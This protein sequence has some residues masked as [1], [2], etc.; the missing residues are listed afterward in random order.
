MGNNRLLSLGMLL[1]LSCTAVGRTPQEMEGL[2]RENWPK[3]ITTP[4]LRITV[5]KP[6]LDSLKGNRIRLRSAFSALKGEASE[7]V[8][9]SFWMTGTLDVS[10]DRK[11]GS[12]SD[13][14]VAEVR[15]PRAAAQDVTLLRQSLE[16]DIPRW[17]LSYPMADLFAE[18]KALEQRKA[19]AMGLKADVPQILFRD[20]PAVLLSIEGEPAWRAVQGT[21]FRRL[22]NSGFF[23]LQ[24]PALDKCYLHVPPYWWSAA[25][26][27]GPWEAIDNAPDAVAEIWTREPKPELP[28]TDAGQEATARPEVLVATQPSELIWTDGPAQFAPI[29]GTNLLFVKNTDSDVFL[30]IEMQTTYVLLSGRWYRTPAQRTAWEFVPSDRLPEDFSR[31]P[32]TSEK[33]HVLAC[34][35][36]TPQA[37]AAVLDAEV[38]QTEAVKPGPAPE[39]EASYD[40]EPQFTPVEGSSVQ[41]AVNTPSSIFSVGRRYYWCN[42]GIWYDSDLAVGPWYVCSWVPPAISLIP[43]SCPS[44]YVTYCRVFSVK[45]SAIWFGYYP[46]YRGCY[47]WGRTIVYGTG[48][49]YRC[50]SGSSWYPR[51]VTWGVG[52]RYNSINCSWGYRYGGYGTCGWTGLRR[53]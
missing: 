31:I 25:E 23:V 34:V 15:F 26:P 38:P 36:G 2:D 1:V 17:R 14:R 50:W 16:S 33:A 41:Y 24:D 51:P 29:S 30:E 11:S 40:G 49:R 32:L 39:M 8:F 21:A 37:Q 27:T 22:A 47:V 12:T 5:Y 18:L 7:P 28:E 4:S 48:W 52:V 42:D 10:D 35:D 45:P 44:Y 46:G 19:Q 43:P 3:E 13:V 53:P 9:G 6:E 20:R